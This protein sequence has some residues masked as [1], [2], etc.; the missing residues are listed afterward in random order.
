MLRGLEH[1]ASPGIHA[2]EGCGETSVADSQ[3]VL[4]LPVTKAPLEHQG[5]RPET[6][7][8]PSKGSNHLLDIIMAKN[9]SPVASHAAHGALAFIFEEP[10][11]HLVQKL[12]VGLDNTE[13]LTQLR[14]NIAGEGLRV[15]DAF[16]ETRLN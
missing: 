13:L 4:D 5:A 12:E 6:L 2:I 3:L 9:P 15:A 7:A 14:N 10:A 8:R 16:A 1:N 11:Q